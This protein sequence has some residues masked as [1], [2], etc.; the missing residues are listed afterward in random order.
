[1][2]GGCDARSKTRP[3]NLTPLAA[4]PPTLPALALDSSSDLDLDLDLDLDSS[5]D[6]DLD[7]DLDLDSSSDLDLDLDLDLDSSSGMGSS[8][9][10]TMTTALQQTRMLLRRLLQLRR[11]ASRGQEWQ[12]Q[13]QPPPSLTASAKPTSRT[14]RTSM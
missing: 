14:N 9:S 7:L 1:M 3:P 2:S 12:P 8:V 10:A 4:V 11:L 5:S 13:L 6:L